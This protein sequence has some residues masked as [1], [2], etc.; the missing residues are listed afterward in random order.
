MFTAVSVS[1]LVSL[2]FT[3]GVI[4]GVPNALALGV[5]GLTETVMPLDPLG[6]PGCTLLNNGEFGT[7]F[8]VLD[9]L[10]TSIFPLPLPSSL[11]F[12][13]L[14]IK[15]QWACVD[16]TVTGGLTYSNGLRLRLC[17]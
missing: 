9:S 7:H 4:R 17:K 5:L 3:P 11:D 1:N 15:Q 6:F 8:V 12:T 10:G 13:G 2:F 14:P 16:S